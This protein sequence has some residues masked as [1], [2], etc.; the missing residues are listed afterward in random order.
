MRSSIRL[1][2][3]FFWALFLSAFPGQAGEILREER[4]SANDFRR[5]LDQV[6]GREITGDANTVLHRIIHA[7]PEEVRGVRASRRSIMLVMRQRESVV[8][9]DFQRKN[10]EKR[11]EDS[12]VADMLFDPYPSRLDF[13]SWPENLDPG[14]Y[15]SDAFF[16]AIYGRTSE[17]VEA[18]LVSVPFL[19]S[20]VQFNRRNGAADALARVG[21]ELEILRKSNPGRFDPYLKKIGG[22]FYWRNIAGTSRLSA[23]SY[24]ISIDLNPDLGGYWQ[25]E[26]KSPLSDMARRTAYPAEIVAAFERQGFVWGGKWYY[27]DLMHFEFRPELL[28]DQGRKILAPPVS[29]T[30]TDSPKP[31]PERNPPPA[32]PTANPVA[33]PT[34]VVP[35]AGAHGSPRDPPAIPRPRAKLTDRFDT[36][37]QPSGVRYRI[38]VCESSP[39]EW[40]VSKIDPEDRRI[41][42]FRAETLAGLAARGDL[43]I[44]AAALREIEARFLASERV[45]IATSGGSLDQFDRD[46]YETPMKTAADPELRSFYES[47]WRERPNVNSPA[48]PP[49]P[50]G[51]NSAD[52]GN[53]DPSGEPPAS[54]PRS[55]PQP[56]PNQQ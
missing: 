21:T 27:F 26:K 12:D 29:A 25:W 18:N 35:A 31:D 7:Y 45:R 43:G 36:A 23:H 54:A 14:R 15:R 47:L 51:E 11:I 16:K 30:P 55:E 40:V 41:E 34:R 24:G 52:P 37:V 6:L 22:A 39:P 44:P 2:I 33:S 20:S 56:Q 5:R 1:G 32:S 10:Y 49:A 8:F 13:K 50:A 4:E 53:P 3:P 38:Q 42:I 46:H 9:E 48:S 17:E 19:G 28:N